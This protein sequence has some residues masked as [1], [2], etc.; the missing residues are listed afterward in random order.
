MK[1]YKLASL[2]RRRIIKSKYSVTSKNSLSRKRVKIIERGFSQQ[3]KVTRDTYLSKEL[4]VYKNMK[5]ILD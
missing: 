5:I 3:L 1:I 2:G 4:E